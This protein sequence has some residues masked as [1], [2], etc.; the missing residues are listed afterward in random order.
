MFEKEEISFNKFYLHEFYDA[1]NENAKL[2]FADKQYSALNSLISNLKSEKEYSAGLEI[3][4]AEHG[5]SE[6]SIFLFDIMD[7]INDYPPTI[8]FDSMPEMVDDFVNTLEVMLEEVTTLESLEKVNNSFIKDKSLLDETPLEPE[9]IAKDSQE[10]VV[11]FSEFIHGEFFI[12]LN[13]ELSS[14]TKLNESEDLTQF[15]K[16]LLQNLQNPHLFN[17]PEQLTDIVDDLNK[18]FTQPDSEIRSTQGFQNINKLMPGIVQKILKLEMDYPEIITES[19]NTNSLVITE[20]AVETAG[21]K[22]DKIEDKTEIIE[23]EKEVAVEK[24]EQPQTSSIENLLSAYFQSEIDEYSAIFKNGFK[25]LKKDPHNIEMLQELENKFH[26]F[27]EISMIHGYDIVESACAG[28]MALLV[29]IR[30]KK[31]EVSNKFF[32]TSND[33]LKELRKSDQF[34]GKTRASAENEKLESIISKMDEAISPA[35]VKEKTS[36]QKKDKIETIKDIE[37]IEQEVEQ[38]LISINDSESLFPIFKEFWLDLQPQLSSELLEKTNI[39]KSVKLIKKIDS[40]AKL[41]NLGLISGICNEIVSR[42]Y[43]L[44]ELSDNEINNGCAI[45]FIIQE[46]VL[47]D[48]QPDFGKEAG[49]IELDKFDSIFTKKI[50]SDDTNSLLSIII[51]LERLNL[52]DFKNSISKIIDLSDKNEKNKQKNHFY[53]L[54][55][56]L[57]LLG[58]NELQEFSKFYFDL[59]DNDE[60]EKYDESINTELV[61]TYKLFIENVESNKSSTNVNDLVETLKEV[62]TEISSTEKDEPVKLLEEDIESEIPEEDLDQIFKEE[63]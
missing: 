11:N 58:L 33:L 55:K 49:E 51:E 15:V 3:L 56:N 59:I 21:E 52:I 29:K 19:I 35:P 10:N 63:D 2:R 54:N 23:E 18:I 38:N 5:T 32:T 26:A 22:I 14:R 57:D 12:T 28:I 1:V 8:V 53:R 4:A 24:E 31:Y 50:S 20:P 43:S 62:I 42:L 9:Q 7:R 36:K 61:Q 16:V 40:A 27:K 34:K 41:I 44:Q 60:F 17:A 30:T 48:L 46:N 13:H 6:L 45:L 39:Q 47:S 37:K 25:N